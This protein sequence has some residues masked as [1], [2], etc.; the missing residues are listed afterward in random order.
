MQK[1]NIK[2][3]TARNEQ[4]KAKLTKEQFLTLTK[5]CQSTSTQQLLNKKLPSQQKPGLTNQ[6]NITPRNNTPKSCRTAQEMKYFLYQKN[7]VKD[8][9][10]KP[11][12]HSQLLPKTKNSLHRNF[13]QLEK[14]STSQQ[15]NVQSTAPNTVKKKYNLLST[16][17]ANKSDQRFSSVQFAQQIA[18]QLKKKFEPQQPQ[19]KKENLHVSLDD[20]VTQI[21]RPQSIISPFK[22]TKSLSPSTR[23]NVVPTKN[24]LYYVSS[25]IESFRHI[26]PQNQ[27]QQLFRDHAVQTFNC[28]SFCVKL[29]EPSKMILEQKQIEIPPMKSNYKFKK[30]V[31]FDLDETLIHCNENQNLRADVYLPITFPSGDKA[32]A[33]INIRPYAKWILQE[34]SQLCEVIV[35]TASHQCYA[36]QVIKYLDP[37][38]TLLSGQLFRDRCVLS[39]DGVHIKDLRVLN[40]DLKDIVLVDNAAYSF[41]VHLENGIPIIPYYDNKEDKE[42]KMLYDF[43]VDQ[44][45]PAP[46][47]RLVLQ[48]VF[49]LREYYNYGEPKQ[50]IEKLY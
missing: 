31:V 2:S 10:N 37:K 24:C 36:S 6:L 3:V 23:V 22:Q 50:A 8:S 19:Q 14:S 42:L 16:D 15:N 4:A 46:D 41:G 5:M 12:N 47:S 43:L 1:T 21:N 20:F 11:Q 45:L 33:G 39:Q 49:R 9:I 35:F 25:L 7:L 32:Q 38:Q 28:V 44:V 34:L 26:I 30:T 13:S 29:Q 18:Q 27:E 40:R 17:S 48:S